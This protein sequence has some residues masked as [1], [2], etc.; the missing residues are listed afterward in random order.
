[1][2]YKNTHLTIFSKKPPELYEAHSYVRRIHSP[3]QSHLLQWEL[4][5]PAA[6]TQPRITAE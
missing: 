5:T 3:K 4:Q 1:M 2:A 6:K